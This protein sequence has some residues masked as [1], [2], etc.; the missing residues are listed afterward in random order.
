MDSVDL[1]NRE[2]QGF[3]ERLK[4]IADVMQNVSRWN[5]NRESVK[6][7]LKNDIKDAYDLLVEFSKYLDK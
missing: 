3:C 2:T 5:V 1:F 6:R 4:D 7:C